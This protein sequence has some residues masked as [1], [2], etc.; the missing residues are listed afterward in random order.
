MI[1]AHCGNRSGV[2]RVFPK[3]TIHALM[4]FLS[5]RIL[6]TAVLF[7]VACAAHAV[8]LD[9]PALRC[10]SVA[11]NGDVT[12]TWIVPADPN[13]D[14]AEYEVFQSNVLG[15]PYVSLGTIPI[16]LQNT[17]IH[18]GAGADLGPRYYYL[19]TRTTSAPPNTSLPSDTLATI[20]LQ[21][22]QSIPLGSAVLDWGAMHTPPLVTSGPQYQI[23][24]EYPVGTWTQIDQVSL[25]TTLYAQV[26]SICE[27]SLTYRIGLSDAQGCISFSS[28]A[29]DVFADATPP[30]SPV[31]QWVSVDT[32]NG[33]ATMQ[34]DPSPELDTDAYIIVQAGPGGN[35]IRDT[36]YGQF[37]TQ[38]QWSGSMA[39]TGSECFTVAAFDTCWTGN[40]PSP[41][42]SPA[43]LPVHCT[44]FTSTTY[45]R[46]N[47]RVTVQWT[48][49]VGWP[50]QYYEVFHRIPGG[51]WI[52]LGSYPATAASALHAGVT[53]FLSYTYLV[54]GYK[55][56]STDSTLSNKAIRFTDYPAVPQFNY[57]SNVTVNAPD[58]LLIENVIDPSAQ[59][60]LYRLERSANGQ[61][62][63]EVASSNAP[64]PVLQFFDTDVSTA[65]TSYQYRIQVDDS[66]GNRV[67]TSNLGNSIL[68]RAQA[69]L[70]GVNELTWNGYATWAGNVSGYAIYRSIEDGPFILLATNPPGVWS[71]IDDV[72]AFDATN[73]RF[74]YVVE[75]LEAGNP[76]GVNAV[77]VSNEACAIQEAQLWVP[78]AFIAGG[79]NNRFVPVTAYTDL[80]DY[81]FTIFNRWGQE[82][83][84]TSVPGDPWKGQVNGSY[85]PQGVYAWYCSFR[86][87]EGRYFE[88]R[89]TV[90]FIWGQD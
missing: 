50:V 7:L 24:L 75:A 81:E 90:T 68:L 37:N 73:G 61:P 20:F 12:L 23:W 62:F 43:S 45:D 57:L 71:Y 36:I 34:W 38:Y 55:V 28:L 77:S 11:P 72:N 58:E 41:N 17:F 40:P 65:Q 13:G 3:A 78:N 46:C 86:N 9:P 33:L 49:Y 8:V 67:L 87:G 63:L 2:Y 74:C 56:G 25:N 59:V 22:N 35:A 69:D 29:G 76:S 18:A 52:L 16:Y 47:E 80:Q 26:I 42:T 48:P 66:C 79:I 30:T 84:T 32:A 1:V 60:R 19:T 14:F 4:R 39:T 85:V 5:V 89:G 44:I 10:A 21:L 15:G 70:S 83:W 53:P 64:G 82:I 27:D 54:K 31:I 51:P 6:G 88:E